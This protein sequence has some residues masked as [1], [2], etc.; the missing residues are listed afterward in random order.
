MKSKLI[1]LLA[2]ACTVLLSSNAGAH[3]ADNTNVNANTCLVA[4]GWGPQDQL[5][6]SDQGVATAPSVNRA[7]TISCSLPRSPLPAGLT[8]GTFYFD[9]DNFGGTTGCTLYSTDY[10]GQFLGSV[11]FTT[12]FPKYDWSMTLPL[13]QLGY[14]AYTD[15][16]CS[17]PPNGTGMLRGFEA[18]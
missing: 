10:T 8:F 7:L 9:G 11:S 18:V 1:V 15:I 12:S 6:H 3:P 5:V 16:L 4:S 13:A 2:A 17:L 14:W